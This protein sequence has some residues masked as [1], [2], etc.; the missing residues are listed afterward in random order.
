MACF[1]SG[2][3]SGSPIEP[4]TSSRNTRLLGPRLLPVDF[5]ALQPDAQ[6]AVFGLPGTSGHFHIDG[7][8]RSVARRRVVVGK[9]VDHFLDSHGI[10]RRQPALVQE[11]A[12]IGI[13]GRI[14]VDRK[15]RKRLPGD[16]TELVVDDLVVLF[17]AGSGLGEIHRV[18]AIP[19]SRGH[20]R[21]PLRVGKDE[22]RLIHERR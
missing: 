15:R 20:L 13:G 12:D 22:R 21:P 5:A 2:S 14:H 11:A 8:G 4:D 19:S 16:R 6:Q 18:I 10:R 9:V 3:L 17:G 1:T 7:K